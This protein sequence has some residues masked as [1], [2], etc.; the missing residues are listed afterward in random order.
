MARNRSRRQVRTGWLGG[1]LVL[2]GLALGLTSARAA[3]DYY[4]I[5]PKTPAG[6][7]PQPPNVPVQ[8][9]IAAGDPHEVL[10][11]HLNALVFVPTPKAIVK[12][13]LTDHGIDI[14]D[15]KVPVPEHFVSLVMPYLGQPV[16]R[17]SLNKMVQSIIVYYRDHDRPGGRRRGARAGHHHG[18]MQVV[19]LEGH[20]G[21]VTVAGN[22]WFSSSTI[23]DGI[24]LQPG[25]EIDSS[26]L[27]ANLDFLNQN[28]FR[29]TDVVYRPGEKL[30]ATDVTLQTRDRFPARV[31]AGY[32]DSGDVETGIDRYFAGFNYGD[33]FGLSQ[34]I[35]YQYTTSGTF[36]SLRAHSG[37]YVIPLPW[38]HTL[39]SSA[40]MSTPRATCPRPSA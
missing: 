13:G 36:D 10:V 31:F 21:K 32:E 25:G 39:T 18:V 27:Q 16:T 5:A 26:Q 28:P 22:R 37:S 38:Q 20:V 8:G 11:K 29:T 1:L 7:P 3:E 12:N 2:T 33:L 17:G 40:A 19:V 4:R 23:R 34:Q 30:G 35:N 14:K 24:F 6:Y 9:K 15:V